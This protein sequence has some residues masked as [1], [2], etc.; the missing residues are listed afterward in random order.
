[1]NVRSMVK[2]RNLMMTQNIYQLVLNLQNLCPQGALGNVIF[3]LIFWLFLCP[4]LKGHLDLPLSV[5]PSVCP[6]KNFVT[7]VEK[8]EHLCPMDTFLVLVFLKI[9]H[10]SLQI[11]LSFI[12]YIV[13][14]FERIMVNGST[15][16]QQM[17]C[18]SMVL[19]YWL[20]LMNRQG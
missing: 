20:M 2:H 17:K 9:Q 8:C 16:N 14:V 4:H 3:I 19:V 11:F 7:K 1:M 5:R 18:I 10:H 15:G 12:A 13:K 6:S